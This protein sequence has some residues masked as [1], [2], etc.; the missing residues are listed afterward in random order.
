M[1]WSRIANLA[2]IKIGLAT[3]NSPIKAYDLIGARLKEYEDQAK[4]IE[5]IQLD[6][7]IGIP[8]SHKASCHFY[9]EKKVI[10]PWNLK[11]DQCRLLNGNAPSPD[12][13]IDKMGKFL[14]DHPMDLCILG[15][16][17]NG[18]LALNEPGSGIMDGCRKVDL[19]SSSQQ[20][21]MLDSLGFKVF[22]GITVG[23]K[24][25]IE[26]KEIILIV[27]GA[28][29]QNAFNRLI[30]KEPIDLCPASVLHLHNNWSCFLD[31]SA[32]N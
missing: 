17:V 22:Q 7:W 16:G 15:L 25:I 18:H 8:S 19:A 21:Q 31:I 20:H 14:A 9:L 26:S 28:N 23:L 4:K 6:E 27:T 24:E 1:L 3:G 2:S 12:L 13:E 11:A 30:S 10:E 29:K 32:I 5:V